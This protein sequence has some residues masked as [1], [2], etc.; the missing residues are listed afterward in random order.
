MR[1][2]QAHKHLRASPRAEESYVR[3][4][5]SI[6][7]SAARKFEHAALGTRSDAISSTSRKA[8]ERELLRLQK[9]LARAVEA[10]FTLMAK[11]VNE[12]TL[13][14]I[15]ALGIVVRR[16][17]RIAE[18]IDRAMR[19]NVMLIQEAASEIANKVSAILEI[20]TNSGLRA[21]ELADQIRASTGVSESRAALIARD[22]TLKLS[23][24]LTQARQ[25]AAGVTS[26]IWSTSNDERV[27]PEHE[28]LS[29]ETFSW[30]APP[31]VGHPGEDIQ[32]RCVAIPII[33]EFA[34]LD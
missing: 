1:R 22:Q 16:D 28:A 8:V 21:E 10:S 29:G 20:P 30:D 7:G 31:D 9:P 27:R 13:K 14:G 24:N 26:Y 32:C 25:V 2:S 18:L 23:G 17:V 4:L 12:S 15:Q 6:L 34:D 3:A 19:S 33:S 11:T 5:R